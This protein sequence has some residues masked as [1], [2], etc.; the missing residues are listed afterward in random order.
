M[1]R[2]EREQGS[3]QS[4]RQKREKEAYLRWYGCIGSRLM[5]IAAC[6]GTLAPGGTTPGGTTGTWPGIPTWPVRTWPGAPMGPPIWPGAP[7]GRR[8]AATWALV[9]TT[10]K[11][12]LTWLNQIGQACPA[13]IRGDQLVRV[14]L[15]KELGHVELLLVLTLVHFAMLLDLEQ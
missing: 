4:R 1:K 10:L 9:K 5:F 13:G 3:R 6:W 11:R 2:R 14:A 12:S 15:V 7:S 8:W